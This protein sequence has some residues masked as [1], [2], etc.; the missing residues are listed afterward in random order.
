MFQYFLAQRARS[1]IH[2]KPFSQRRETFHHHRMQR[3]SQHRIPRPNTH[4]SP[5]HTLHQVLFFFEKNAYQPDKSTS[6]T[7]PHR[8]EEFLNIYSTRI[9]IDPVTPYITSNVCTTE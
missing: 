9:R 8:P 5:Y 3:P 1:G 2:S 4:F 7:A 6:K